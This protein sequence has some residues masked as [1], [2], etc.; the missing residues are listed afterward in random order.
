MPGGTTSKRARN[1][2]VRKTNQAGNVGIKKQQGTTRIIYDSLPID[3]GTLFEFFKD[4]NRVF[5]FSNVG[6]RGGELSVGEA[7]AVQRAYFSVFEVDPLT[8]EIVDISSLAGAGLFNQ[9]LGD[10]NLVIANVQTIKPIPALS[11][12]ARFNKNAYWDDY[13]NFEFDTDI[14]IQPLLEFSM[15]LRTPFG[16]TVADTFLRL[17]VEG[18]GA[19][20]SPRQPQ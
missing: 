20:L 18:V 2:I 8:G 19:I 14:V 11:Q 17:T 13:N 4:N 1:V 5:P 16:V 7:I 12:D 10:L 15:N 9:Q 3:G 6:Q